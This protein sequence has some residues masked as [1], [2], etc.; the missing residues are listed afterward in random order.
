MKAQKCMAINAYFCTINVL[1][2]RFMTVTMLIEAEIDKLV[3]LFQ[4]FNIH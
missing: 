4:N 1:T 3:V 2:E